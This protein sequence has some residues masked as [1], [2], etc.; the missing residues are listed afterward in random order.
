M[1]DSHF[2]LSDMDDCTL[3]ILASISATSRCSY[4]EISQIFCRFISDAS[5]D[6]RSSWRM[7][8]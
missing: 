3:P 5:R 7:F 8:Q 1:N 6:L 4:Q 2:K